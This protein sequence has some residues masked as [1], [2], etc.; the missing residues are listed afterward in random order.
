[1]NKK[2]W[3]LGVQELMKHS[4]MKRDE[5]EFAMNIEAGILPGDVIVAEE[6]GS[7]AP[8]SK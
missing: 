4:G 3:E 7:D 8:K 5:A 2:E 1:M 6:K